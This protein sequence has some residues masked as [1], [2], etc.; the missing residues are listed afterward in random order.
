[1]AKISQGITTEF[2]GQDGVSMAPL[3]LE[4]IDSW[5]KNIAGLDGVQIK[6]PGNM[7][8]QKII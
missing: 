4:Y 2:L 6:F 5:I 8:T 7:K 3:P 1:M